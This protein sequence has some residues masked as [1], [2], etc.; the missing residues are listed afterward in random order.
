MQNLSVLSPQQ[1][2]ELLPYNALCEDI[3][4]AAR[5]YQAGQIH[6][7]ERQVLPLQDSAVLLSMPATT[8]D[9]GIHKL[10]NVCPG[11]QRIGLPT[12]Q[13]IVSVYD[14]ASGSPR[15]LLDGP[16]VTARRT[17]AVTLLAMRRLLPA[18][19]GHIAV[20]GCGK[21][22]S[23]HLEAF[24]DQYP[25]MRVDVHGRSQQQ[26]RDFIE[27]HRA[28]PLQ[29]LAGGQAVD[30]AAE[31]VVTLTT[32]KTPVYTQAAQANRLL[33]GV[34]AFKPD[35]VEYGATP[36][37]G[38]TIYIDDTIGA[39]H[40]A[41]DLIQ[42]GIDWNT[43]Q[44]LADAGVAPIDFTRPRLFKSVGTGAWDLA[45]ARCALRVLGKGAG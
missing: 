8:H 15:L 25:G 39:R 9:I 43:V 26:V 29:L 42:A 6:C 11:N 2:A 44:S 7:P 33:V 23:A 31:V 3:A 16:T 21:Q 13:G 19:P 37:H 40:E 38:S 4:Q 1:T 27:R 10:V 32:S 17:A 28:L 14:A 30:D 20:F 12:I 36:V 18:A 45:A 35:M 22:T 41:G 5:D 24:A 34:G